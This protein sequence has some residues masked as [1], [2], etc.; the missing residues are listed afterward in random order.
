M[1]CNTVGVSLAM[2]Q[3]SLSILGLG[4]LYQETVA[5]TIADVSP[6]AVAAMSRYW[7]T[8]N[9]FQYALQYRR[10]LYVDSGLGWLV[11]WRIRHRRYIYIYLSIYPS[12][13][14]SILPSIYLS[15]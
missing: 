15:I 5:R 4:W 6:A 14:L 3:G 13:Y 10:G 2:P 12:I 1:H 11:E 7:P 9:Q 8:V